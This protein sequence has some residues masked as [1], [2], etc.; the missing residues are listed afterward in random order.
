MKGKKVSEVDNE[1]RS[2]KKEERQ[3]KLREWHKVDECSDEGGIESEIGR[4]KKCKVK[5]KKLVNTTDEMN[6]S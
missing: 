1:N 3:N 4:N 5:F 2:Q 6:E